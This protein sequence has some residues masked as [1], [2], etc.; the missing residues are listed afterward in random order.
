MVRPGTF[1][2]LMTISLAGPPGRR[3]GPGRGGEAERRGHPRRRPG[4]LGPGLLWGRDPDPEPG[5]ARGRRAA[6]HA[7]LQHGAVL[8]VAGGDPHGVLCPAGPA[9]QGARRAQRR[10]GDAAVVGEAPAG[11]AQAARLPL[12]PL[13][14]VA[15]RRDA[16]GQRLRP[17]LLPAGRRAIFRPALAPRGR[18][19]APPRRPEVRLLLDDRHRRPRDQ[20]PRRARGETRRQALLPVPRIHLAAFPVACQAGGHRPVS[21]SLSRGVGRGPRGALGEDPGP[22]VWS[23]AASPRS[24]EGSGRPTTSRT[25]CGRSAPARSTGPSR[26]AS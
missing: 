21:R 22:S 8:A 7:V 24:S 20:V 16:D 6:V 17:L 26:G 3:R 13:G 23:V 4:V 18:Q 14:Q 9:R 19:E 11:E 12:V 25:P 5:R 2:F 1:L 15:R 10:P